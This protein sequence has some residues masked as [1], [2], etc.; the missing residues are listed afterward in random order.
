MPPR[1]ATAE[2]L[3]EYERGFRRAGLPMF[4][5]DFSAAEDVFNRA[6]PLLGLVFFG[7]IFG[8][9]DSDWPWWQNVLA[10][11]GALAFLLRA[12]GLINKAQGR[13]FSAIPRADRQDRAGRRSCCVPAILPELFNAQH[14]SA[15]ATAGT[16]L[17]LLVLIYAF[18]VIRLHYMVSWIFGRF[19]GQIR[20]AFGLIATAIPLLAIFALLSFTTQELWEIFSS[21]DT[22]IYAVIIGM[23]V[24][25]GFLFLVARIPRE[26]SKLETD[27]GEGSPPLSRRQ[28]MN[29]GLVM[30]A[31]QTLQ[32]LIVSITIGVFFTAF[33]VLAIDAEIRTDWIGSPGDTVFDFDFLGENFQVTEELLRVSGGLA[34]FSGFYFAISMLTDSTYR[35]EFL[36][37]LTSEMRESFT[38]RAEYLKLRAGAGSASGAPDG[39][40]D[41]QTMVSGYEHVPGQPLR[42]H[43]PAQPA[44]LP[45]LRDQRGD[46]LRPRGRSVLLLRAARRPVPVALH[47]RPRRRGWR[48]TSWS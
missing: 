30:L 1:D 14:T 32:V 20:S 4:V 21:V 25:L 5:E 18:G 40:R 12:F 43:G 35:E 2:R 22:D 13:A 37:E 3:Q 31:S 26:A 47:Q 17:L 28:L 15:I 19:A 10:V 23:F 7:E 38:E 39:D 42:L 44:R 27:A 33:G 46:G 36:S 41:E 29:V 11:L 34:A 24:V 48:R 9:I 16:N 45:R 6:A 8:A